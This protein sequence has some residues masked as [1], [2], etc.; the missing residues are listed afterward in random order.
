M[1][2]ETKKGKGKGKDVSK[3]QA[4]TVNREE[5]MSEDLVL[6]D[7]Y[8]NRNYVLGDMFTDFHQFYFKVEAIYC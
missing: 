3:P 2:L 4:G 6:E 5:Q 7:V 8:V 1:C